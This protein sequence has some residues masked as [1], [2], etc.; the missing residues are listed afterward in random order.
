MR[1]TR[2]PL[3]SYVFVA[4]RMPHRRRQRDLLGDLQ[5]RAIPDRNRPLL[6]AESDTV[7]DRQLR[8]PLPR[9]AGWPGVGRVDVSA[10]R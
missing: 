5:I 8:E 3:I 1:M 6:S 4:I 2:L 10:H 9:L 7:C